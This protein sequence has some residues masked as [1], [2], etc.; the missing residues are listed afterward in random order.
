M[1]LKRLSLLFSSLLALIA[2]SIQ[3]A[4]AQ[5]GVPVTPG[6]Q[7]DYIQLSFDLVSDGLTAPTGLTHA[8]DGSGR[9]FVT[10]QTGAIRIIENGE[11]LAEPFLDISNEILVGAEQG[12]LGLAFD[13]DYENNGYFYLNYSDPNGDTVVS[14]VSVSD[15]DPNQADFLS[16]IILLQIEQPFTNHNGGTMIF[17]PDGYLYIS[18]G[19]GGSGGDPQGNAQNRGNLL[20]NL[21]RIDVRDNDTSDGL[22]YDI[23]AD[24]PFVGD[25][26]SQD[27]IW[28]YGLRNPWKFSFDSQTGDLYIADVGQNTWEEVNYQPADSTGG[29]NYGWNI[30]EGPDCF[31]AEA[32]ITIG[33]PPVISYNHRTG[34]RSITGGYVYR[35]TAYPFLDGAYLYADYVSGRVWGASQINDFADV[36]ELADTDYRITGFGEDEAG[37]LYIL[38]GERGE[39]LQIQAQSA[40]EY[41]NLTDN[42]SFESNLG[43]DDWTI[44]GSDNDQRINSTLAFNGEHLMLFQADD[45]TEFVRQT[46]PVEG[47]APGDYQASFAIASRDLAD[48]GQ[49]GIRVILSEGESAVQTVN[50]LYDGERGSQNWSVF[51][52]DVNATVSFDSVDLI[53]GWQGVSAGLLG[54]DNV[55]FVDIMPLPL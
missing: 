10:E 25:P 30:Y 53:I 51:A 45:A 21:L 49:I 39:V 34:N 40:L 33:T 2:F 31:E 47:G 48:D 11:L 29:Q 50:C 4:Q 46:V 44:F 55:L 38:D 1:H 6:P 19:D 27:E 12:L 54:I 20:G 13:P 26:D 23:P 37:E 42:A 28:A 14:R 41:T 35:G 3:P 52:C 22:A 36:T 17:G 43:A 9:L 7:F 8:G 16:E 15:N 24:N 5:T 18:S 32:C